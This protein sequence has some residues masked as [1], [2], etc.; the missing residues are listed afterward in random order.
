MN[1][2]PSAQRVKRQPTP[3]IFQYYKDLVSGIEIPYKTQHAIAVKQVYRNM[4]I[5]ID[6]FT[7]DEL[8][9]MAKKDLSS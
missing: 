6:G 7:H 4:I 1:S 8:I 2:P 3:W 9:D 5:H